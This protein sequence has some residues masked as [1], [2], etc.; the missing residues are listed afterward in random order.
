MNTRMNQELAQLLPTELISACQTAE[1]SKGK[2]LFSEGQKPHWMFYVTCGEI[3]LIRHGVEGE[4]AYLQRQQ[5]GFV[6]EASLVSDRYHCHAIALVH[7][8]IIKVPIHELKVWLSRD[9][10]FSMRWIKMLSAEVRRVRL[11]NE[12]LCLTTVRGRL[13]HLLDTESTEGVYRLKGSIKLLAQQLAVSY[14]ALYR[15]L[16]ALEKEGQLVRAEKIISL[17]NKNTKT[18]SI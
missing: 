10:E 13:L 7:S 2:L 16:A 6:G 8:E 5:N 1:F 14:E 18:L 17:S 3:A 9:T 4:T 11:Q 15:C 12:R